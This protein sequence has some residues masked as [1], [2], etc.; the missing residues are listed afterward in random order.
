V[1][2][3]IYESIEEACSSLVRIRRKPLQPKRAA[4]RMYE[5]SYLLFQSLY[6]QVHSLY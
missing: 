1:G 4:N 3:G 6:E 5:K 2:C